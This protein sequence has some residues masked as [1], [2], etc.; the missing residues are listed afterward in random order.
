LSPRRDPPDAAINPIITKAP[1]SSVSAPAAGK[2]AKWP[3]CGAEDRPER[4]G[5]PPRDEDCRRDRGGINPNGHV[6]SGG[7]RGRD[8]ADAAGALGRQ[9]G[10]EDGGGEEHDR[11]PLHGQTMGPG[12]NTRA[13][14]IISRS[15]PDQ[16][17]RLLRRGR[18][19][20]SATATT[21]AG[22]PG[23]WTATPR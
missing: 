9:G 1:D 14:T 13:S 17:R 6:A 10:G 8:R 7:G 18:L 15:T 22:R 4:A 12:T 11:T 20:F 3:G 21:A 23:G 5:R 2:S 19:G 16:S